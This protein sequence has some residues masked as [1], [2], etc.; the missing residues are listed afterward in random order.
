M[1]KIRLTKEFHFE[2]SHA[3]WN[4]DGKCKHIHGHS[5]KLLVTLL[6]TPVCDENSPKLGMLMDFGDLKRL[7]NESIVDRYDH[8]LVLSDKTPHEMLPQTPQLFD[9]LIITSYQPT[10]EN[11]LIEFAELL[12]QKLPSNIQL[13]SLRLHETPTSFAEWYASDN[14]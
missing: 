11:L 1:Q 6:G 14:A 10:C 2:A 9:K 13:F 12:K 7:V 8:A 3:L 5:Y 4:H